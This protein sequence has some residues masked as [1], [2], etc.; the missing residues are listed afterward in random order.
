MKRFICS[1]FFVV[2]TVICLIL[3]IVPATLTAMGFGNMVSS[4][5]TTVLS[6]AQKLFSYV[7]DGIGGFAE[8]FTEYDRLKE[9]NEALRALL[10]EMN[11]EVLY[12]EDLEAVNDWLFGYLELKREHT[13]LTLRPANVT[14]T[15]NGNYMTVFTL[16]CGTS[17]GVQEDMTVMTSDGIVGHIVEA[18]AS[19]SKAVTFLEAG[20]SVGAV[21]E[22]SG[23]RGLVEG[24][25]H[26]SSRGM[27][28]MTYLSADSDARVGDRVVT[29]GTG[30][31]YPEGLV[32]GYVESVETDPLTRRR[33]AYIEAAADLS[34]LSRIMVI[35][36]F[37]TVSDSDPVTEAVTD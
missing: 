30:G 25:F 14:G 20:V 24:D 28:R 4:A 23:E 6:P 26:L 2:V 17:H 12:A 22:R 13:D 7:A 15:G 35:T 36:G 10:R 37:E 5:V 32:I 34:H 9:E 27:C 3:T 33:V 1:R 11:D 16:D 8:Y 29:T 21:I 18:G 31:V 19:W